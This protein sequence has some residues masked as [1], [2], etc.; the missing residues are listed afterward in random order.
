MTALANQPAAT[1]PPASAPLA[2]GD[3]AHLLGA[4]SE[5]TAKLEATHEALRGEVRRLK[6]ELRDANEQIERSRRLAALGEM[7]A[8]IAH[9]VRN[10]LASIGLYARILEQELAERPRERETAG[11]ILASVR[12]LD[13]VVCDVLAFAREMRVGRVEAVASELLGRALREVQADVDWAAAGV[14]VVRHDLEADEVELECDTGLVHRALVNIIRNAVQAMTAH[15]TGRRELILSAAVRRVRAP[16]AGGPST[17]MAVLAVRD[18]GPGIPPE[19]RSRMFNPFFT[20]RATGTGLGLAIVHRIVDA[21]G[22][23]VAV[24][25]HKDGG[26]IVELLL[27]V[28]APDAGRIAGGG[29]REDH[30]ERQEDRHGADLV[31]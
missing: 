9:E 29:H 17:T 5:V 8:G 14:A 28:S 11:K 31:R 16:A 18:T 24:R 19:V 20:T 27:P 6:D 1:L 13:A 21:H 26:A 22:G 3:L 4:F 30:G 10:P 2:E 23:R 12:G 15:A 25:N 7:A